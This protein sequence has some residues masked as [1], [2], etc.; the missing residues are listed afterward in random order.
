MLRLR[1]SQI[2]TTLMD[3]HRKNYSAIGRNTEAPTGFWGG[4]SV[5][6][7]TVP[8]RPLPCR[9]CTAHRRR[10]GWAAGPPAGLGID[11][12]STVRTSVDCRASKVP[13]QC[14]HRLSLAN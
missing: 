7:E 10:H 5:R 2:G 8:P 9:S 14:F 1:R 13:R 12:P 3:Q 4:S 11:R 6:S